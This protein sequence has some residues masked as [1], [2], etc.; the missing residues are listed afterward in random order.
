MGQIF[1]LVTL[2]IHRYQLRL[3]V[4]IALYAVAALVGFARIYVGAQYPRDVV[5][6]VV[7]GSLWGV[8]IMLVNPYELPFPLF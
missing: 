1:F 5:A 6:G 4:S 7:L 2:F 3:G 8:L